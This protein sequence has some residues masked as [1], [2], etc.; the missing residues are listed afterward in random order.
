MRVGLSGRDR[1]GRRGLTAL[2]LAILVAIGIG[3]ATSTR[4]PFGVSIY[5]VGP[6]VITAA[7]MLTGWI[8]WQRRPESRI[9]MMLQVAGVLYAASNLWPVDWAPLFTVA[10]LLGTFYRNVLG[11]M[12]LAFPSGRLRSRG[13]RALVLVFYA[14]GLIGIPFTSMF[15]DPKALCSCLPRN[16]ALITSAPSLDRGLNVGTSIVSVVTATLFVVVMVRHWRRAAPTTRRALS[17]VYWSG[18][19]AGTFEAVRQVGDAIDAT[20]QTSMAWA[21][22][23]AAVL[24]ALP[25]CF[26]IGLLRLRMA[27]G[28]VGDLVV[29]L[30]VDATAE[31]D[32]TG[33]LA[34]RLGDPTLE[35][36]YR[37]SEGSW[38]D[39]A[40]KGVD[41]P[42]GGAGRILRLLEADGMPFAALTL[43]ARLDELPELVEATVG[44]AR[45]AIV[46]G[47]LRAEVQAQ[48]AEVFASRK[49]IVEAADRARRKVER[50]LHDGAQQRLVGLSLGL[51]LLEDQIEGD[52]GLTDQ[53]EG[54]QDE[55]RGAL[56]E[57]RELARGLH[58]TILTEEG[59]G[60]AIEALAERAPFPVSVV[61]ADEDRY[62]PPIEATAYFLVAEALTNVAKYAGASSVQVEVARS[63][64]TLSIDVIDDGVG[65]ASV[66]TGSGLTGLDDR[67]AAVGGWLRVESPACGGTRVH[68]EMPAT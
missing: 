33:T 26:L 11:H 35:L 34:R 18:A 36:A 41:Q 66:G 21:W 47:R 45:L 27:R 15:Q 57:L 43:D 28:A 22:V 50:D 2:A 9:G 30:G 49:R 38:V 62:P 54:L 55:L 56:A 32:L 23:E 6:F 7:F 4:G 65:G 61:F 52:P 48:L 59:L 40:G 37:L 63:N 53:I 64:G 3:L 10:W 1:W 44:A 17:V 60:A 58:P 31:E 16:L 46:N 29:E 13:E 51:R 42:T 14:T 68:A 24:L 25:V 5:T 20:F 19:V 12:L 8:G 39:D 67:V